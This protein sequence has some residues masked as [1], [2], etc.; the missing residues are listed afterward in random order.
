V[1][2]CTNIQLYARSV[3]SWNLSAIGVLGEGLKQASTPTPQGLAVGIYF[4]VVRANRSA[5]GS[6]VAIRP[7]Q[8]PSYAYFPVL[9]W[10]VDLWTSPSDRPKPYWTCGQVMINF[11]VD[12]N[13]TTLLGL[14]PT[15]STAFQQQAFQ[16]REKQLRAS[17]HPLG[18]VS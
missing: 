8:T 2:S 14:S 7:K 17:A 15:G 1:Q 10:P 4:H 9:L 11:P 18:Q 12:H 6:V 3:C 13:S 16:K 5:P